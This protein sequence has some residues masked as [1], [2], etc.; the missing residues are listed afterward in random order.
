MS[1]GWFPGIKPSRPSPVDL[2]TGV[3][4]P[5][6]VYDYILGG[7]D[8][9]AADQAAAQAAMATNPHVATAMRANRAVMRR[10]AA[11]LARDRG[12]RQFLD[13]GTGLP[14]SPNMHEIVQAIAPQ[15]H[16]VYVDSDPIVLAHARAL[17]SSGSDGS[18]AYLDADLRE[19]EKILADPQLR[20]T[21]DLSQPTALMLFGILH[22][23]PDSDDPYGVVARL[24]SALAP[25]SYLAIQHA[26]A[27]FYPPGGG[28]A[29]AFSQAGIA[30][31]YRTRDEFERFLTGLDLV[32]PGIVPMAE[33]RDGDEPQ[34]RPS[35]LEAGGYA[36]VG[37]K[38]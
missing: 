14:T 21:L 10:M 6:R 22:F 15:A 25:G 30:F 3:P 18:C 13:I 28:T 32:P 17:L 9:F 12:I 19:P 34:P 27:D 24:V 33:W 16:V 11:F 5:A 36:A 23:V 7:K 4:H 35:P 8:N 31:Q 2:D 37:R 20:R 29:G 26:T 1:G 38:D